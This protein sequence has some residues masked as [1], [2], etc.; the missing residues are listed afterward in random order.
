MFRILVCLND[1]LLKLRINRVLTIKNYQYDIT[2]NP[3]KRDDLILYDIVLIH[4]SYRLAN[5]HGFIENSILQELTTLIYISSNANSNPFR[6]LLDHP[7]IVFVDENKMDVELPLAIEMYKKYSQQLSKLNR[8]NKKLIKSVDEMNLMNKCKRM[9]IKKGYSEEEA[10]KYILK[11][12]MDN[13]IDKYEACN[14][15]LEINSE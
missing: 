8:E 11:F 15:L 2:D 10:H 7:N 4:S 9:I 1:G 3:I 12:A 5:L 13:H 6:K 14:R